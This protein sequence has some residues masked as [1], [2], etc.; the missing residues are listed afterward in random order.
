M[1]AYILLIVGR[2]QLGSGE[3]DAHFRPGLQTAYVPTST[4]HLDNTEYTHG[5]FG[6]TNLYIPGRML[7]FAV[8]AQHYPALR[9]LAV[10]R[11]LGSPM[12][13]LQS[14]SWEAGTR[15]NQRGAH[16][17]TYLHVH[18][19]WRR[20]LQRRGSTLCLRIYW[21]VGHVKSTLMSVQ[22]IC[23]LSGD[24]A[25]PAPARSHPTHF[26]RSDKIAGMRQ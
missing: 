24:R 22:E 15:H 17:S 16:I 7:I 5:I 12:R 26:T 25:S 2:G 19:D 8:M 13:S 11:T 10:M 6:N 4:S 9:R 1:V 14:C 3:S 21:L 18:N 20:C 23:S